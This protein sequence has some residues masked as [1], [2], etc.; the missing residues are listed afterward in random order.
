MTSDARGRARRPDD[1]APEMAGPAGDLNTVPGG[2]E[3]PVLVQP[4]DDESLYALR[5]AVAAHAGW[6]GLPPD[7]ADDLV[8]AVHE[9]AA[10]A[11]RHGA[12]HGRVRLWLDGPA[13]R[14]EV[15]DDGPPPAAGSADGPAGRPASQWPVEHGHGLWLV[16]EVADEFSLRSVDGGATANIAFRLTRPG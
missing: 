16:R 13:V 2:G 11:V 12:G 7:R 14:C 1:A 4:F 6:A 9:L 3:L 5:A 8:V 15:A 10:N